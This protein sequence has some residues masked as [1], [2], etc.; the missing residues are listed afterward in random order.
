[1]LHGWGYTCDT[2]ICL[3]KDRTRV[4]KDMTATHATVKQL[5]KSGRA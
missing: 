3:R 5:A 1:M 2:N 4:T